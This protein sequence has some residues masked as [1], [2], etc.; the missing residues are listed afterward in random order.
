MHFLKDEKLLKNK[1][2]QLKNKEKQV[3]ALKSLTKKELES[4]QGIFT[5][6]MRTDEI[7]N[8]YMELKN[9]KIKLNKKI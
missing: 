1:Q 2:K 9:G 4:V 7:K 5:K 8:E 3:E 6:N